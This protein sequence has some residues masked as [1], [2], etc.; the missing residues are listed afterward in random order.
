VTRRIAFLTAEDARD[1]RFWSGTPYH[2]A[3][4]LTAQ[5][6]EVTHVGPMPAWPLLALRARKKLEKSFGLPQSLVTGSPAYARF[7][8][9]VAGRRIAAL[10]PRPDVVFSPAGSA[11]VAHLRTEAPLVYL[12]DATVR[13]M[14]GY[15]PQ[16]TGLSRGAIRAADRLE[17]AAI[18][19]AALLVY[20]TRWVADSA[21]RDYG[22]DPSKI[23]VAPLGANMDDA[24]IGGPAAP[25]DDGV[26]RLLFVGTEWERKGGDI[27][28]AALKRLQGRGVPSRLTLVGAAPPGPVGEGVEAVGFLDKNRPADRARL[29][30]LYREAHFFILPTR[31]ECYGIVFCEAAAYGVPSLATRTG[32]VPDVVAEGETGFTLP[33][34]DRG[35]GY[36]AAI[37]ALWADPA[38]YRALRASSRRAYE[39]RLNWDAWG[40]AVMA[41]IEAV[42]AGRPPAHRAGAGQAI[43][44]EGKATRG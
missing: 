27:A 39:T 9:L 10:A 8:G 2:I 14:V 7:A 5:G 3:A 29:A 17:R 21:V 44:P 40:R 1:P 33:P 12:S 28:L 15:Y 42:L 36:A 22:A 34:E 38:R 23:L 30:T 18:T 24:E 31:H 20:P 16:F 35:E 11:L 37:A 43:D 32:G 41:G 4:S 25:P 26:C 6:A 13:L 19:R